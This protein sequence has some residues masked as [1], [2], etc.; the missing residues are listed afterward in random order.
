MTRNTPRITNKETSASV[1]LA[2]IL[3]SPFVLPIVEYGLWTLVFWIASIFHQQPIYYLA[4]VFVFFRD[5]ENSSQR[6]KGLFRDFIAAAMTSLLGW[7]F[8]D[9]LSWGLGFVV[10]LVAGVVLIDQIIDEIKLRLA[11]WLNS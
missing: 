9:S 8:S 7:I 5:L 4:L 10:A 1:D 11:A 6:R 2:I 3:R